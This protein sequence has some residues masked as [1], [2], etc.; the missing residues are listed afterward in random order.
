MSSSIT[1]MPALQEYGVPPLD[2][3][4]KIFWF[5]DG[6]KDSSLD[7]V[8]ASINA[9]KANHTDFDSGK[10]GYLDFMCQQA[11]TETPRP[12][13]LPLLLRLCAA[14]SPDLVRADVG[15]D[16]DPTTDT[17]RICSR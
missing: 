10:D 8:R 6:I 1:C 5:Q 12:D 9:N 17:R 7:A 15:T 3:S 16:K 13:R 11:P 14:A 2:K 4:P